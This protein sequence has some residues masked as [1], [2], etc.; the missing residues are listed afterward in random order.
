MRRLASLIAAAVVVAGCVASGSPILANPSAP[1]PSIA[2]PSAAPSPPADP[3]PI[4]LPRDDGPHDRLT[5]WWY[6]TGHLIGS[7]ASMDAR[8]SAKPPRFGFE[9]VN[10]RPKA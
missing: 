4:V 5:E 8:Y 2:P 10:E 3:L 9:F 7:P 6:Y 1:R